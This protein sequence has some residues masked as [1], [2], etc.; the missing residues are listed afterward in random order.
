ML[1]VAILL[2]LAL[3]AGC[4]STPSAS[5]PESP[6]ALVLGTAQDGGL[7]QIGC[8]CS[9]SLTLV[10]DIFPEFKGFGQIRPIRMAIGGIG[11]GVLGHPHLAV[12]AS[13]LDDGR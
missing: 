2:A 4:R 6:Y 13:R 12:P 11:F 7:P 10:N 5:F 3:V 9:N 8:A 1:R